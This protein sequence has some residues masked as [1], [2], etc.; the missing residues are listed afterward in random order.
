MKYIVILGDGMA[1]YPVAELGEKTPLEVAFKP[2]IDNMAK[3]GEL[4]LVKTV[5]DHLNPPGSD[6][7]NMSVLGYNPDE[8]YTG[9]SP[10]EAVSMGISMEEEDLAVRCNLVTLSD[11]PVYEDKR[12]IDYSADEISTEEA[13]E[14]ILFLEKELGSDTMRL[15]PGISYRHCLIYRIPGGKISLQCTPPHDIAEKCIRNYL[16]AAPESAVLLDMMKK[17][18]ALLSAHPVNLARIARGKRPANSL[19]FW[20]EGRK[21]G[22]ADFYKIRGLKGAVVSAVDL[23]KGL[24][25]CAGMEVISVPGATGTIDTN[26]TGKAQAALDFLKNRGDFVYLHMEAPDECG[27]RHE[28]QN[29]VKSIELIDEKVV[30]PIKEALDGL[31]DYRILVMPDH[32]TPLA[33][34]TH[35]HDAVPYLIYDSRYPE[36]RSDNRKYTEADAGNTGVYIGEGYTLMHRFLQEKDR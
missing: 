36:I 12:M 30:G 6:I 8:Y 1:D 18:Y 26:F 35:T 5:P 17:S 4:G 23:V 19:W 21:P 24:G 34:R 25:I 2:N 31:D 16:P 15:Y 29:K 11:E 14:L 32:P 22:L 3:R 33:L 27:H 28:V 7:A 9:R 13:R 20:G 10:L